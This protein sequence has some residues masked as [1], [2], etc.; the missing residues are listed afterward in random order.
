MRDELLRY[1][2]CTRDEGIRVYNYGKVG[3]HHIE[4]EI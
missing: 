3:I 4:Y 2:M 1:I